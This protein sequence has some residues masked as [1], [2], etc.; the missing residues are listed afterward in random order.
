MHLIKD[1]DSIQSSATLWYSKMVCTG[2]CRWWRLALRSVMRQIAMLRGDRNYFGNPC[3]NADESYTDRS[4]VLYY[5]IPKADVLIVRY[6]SR[7]IAY[8]RIANLHPQNSV[9]DSFTVIEHQT[10]IKGYH[11][12]VN[13]WVTS[14]FMFPSRYQN[15]ANINV[16]SS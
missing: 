14:T 7:M 2:T 4:Q 5:G 12:F 1:D 8:L 3:L 11:S 16:A 10:D 6:I 13:I 9:Q 15:A